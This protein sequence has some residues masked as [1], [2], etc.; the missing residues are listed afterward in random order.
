MPGSTQN[1]INGIPFTP[2]EMIAMHEPIIFHVTDDWFDGIAPFELTSDAAS[3]TAL[4]SCLEYFNIGHVVTTI[5]QINITSLGT[6][7]G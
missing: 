4:L 7:S 5:S 2:F 3:D 1:R 6:L